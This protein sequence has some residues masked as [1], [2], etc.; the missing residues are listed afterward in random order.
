MVLVKIVLVGAFAAVMLGVAKQQQWFERAGLVSSCVRVATPAGQPAGGSW[1]LC[2]EGVL[3]GFPV[4]ERDNCE[5]RGLVGDRELWHCDTLT[6]AL[7]MNN[8]TSF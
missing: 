5:S 2:R 4:L 6:D 8:S 1:R 3:T 7:R